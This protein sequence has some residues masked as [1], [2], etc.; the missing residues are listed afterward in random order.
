[1][2]PSDIAPA[3]RFYGDLAPWW[4]LISPV[5]DY[6]DEARELADLFARASRPVRRVLELGSGGGHVAFHLK[7]VVALTLTDVSASMLERSTRLN[8]ECRH[9][10]GD[11]RSLRLGVTF[12]AVVVH[13][14]IDYMTSETDLA[15]AMATAFEHC[16]PGGLALFVPDHVAETFAPSTD[17]GGS[18]A[19][20]GRGVRYLEWS[21]DSDPSDTIVTTHY[22]FLLREADGNVTAVAETHASG[23]F[24]QA[25]WLRLLAE[26]GFRPD[27][28]V[29]RTDEDREPRRIFLAHRAG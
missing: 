11:M 9:L 4:P 10:S 22:A 12:D 8:P 21:Y 5:E 27:V 23:L 19:A 15:R 14:A 29:E 18:D 2:P 20:D 16:A 24:P 1:M 26:A 7:R 3:Y 17:C 25:T 28:R 13:D 6:A